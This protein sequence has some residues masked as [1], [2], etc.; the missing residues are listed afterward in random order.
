MATQQ[1]RDKAYYEER[2][3][4]DHPAI[5]ADLIAGKYRTVTEAA[6]AAGLRKPRT[7][8][9][10]LKNA[11]ENA[12][13]GEQRESER[14]L[15][16]Q[17]G[18]TTPHPTSPNG[19]KVPI[20][21]DRRLLPWAKSRIRAIMSHRHLKIGDVMNEMGLPIRNASVGLALTNDSRLQPQV[22]IALEAWLEKNKNV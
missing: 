14:W 9:Q 5:Y 19:A 21:N 11:W 3:I 8:L 4:R 10:E 20:A 12:S 6:I 17:F 7:R 13:A 16:T 1:K 22:L 15:H 18:L 2:L